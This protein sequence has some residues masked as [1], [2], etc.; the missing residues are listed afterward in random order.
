MEKK[1]AIIFPPNGEPLK[2]VAGADGCRYIYA[3]ADGSLEIQKEESVLIVRGIPF[4]V[5]KFLI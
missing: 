1:E 5:E 4:M 3:R 2:F